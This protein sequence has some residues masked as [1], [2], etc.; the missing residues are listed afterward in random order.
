V[1]TIP[2][3]K[4]EELKPIRRSMDQLELNYFVRKRMLRRISGVSDEEMRTAI[5]EVHKIQ[6]QR[7][8][9]RRLQPLFKLEEVSL[10]LASKLSIRKDK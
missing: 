2:V 7:R 5:N 9:T 8:R 6:K 4:Y 10:M 1:E 3:D